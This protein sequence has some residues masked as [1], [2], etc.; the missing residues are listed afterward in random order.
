MSANLPEMFQTG[1][2][3]LGLTG[4]KLHGAVSAIGQCLNGKSGS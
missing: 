4:M 3:E 1:T 2:R